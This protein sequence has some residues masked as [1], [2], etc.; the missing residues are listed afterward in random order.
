MKRLAVSPPPLISKV[1]MEP[2]PWG[3]Y[4]PYSALAL[5]LARRGG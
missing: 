1:K 3:K 5:P 4:R 2:A